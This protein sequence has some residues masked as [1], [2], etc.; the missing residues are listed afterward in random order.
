VAADETKPTIWNIFKKEFNKVFQELL[1]FES[2]LLFDNTPQAINRLKK[3]LDPTKEYLKIEIELTEGG[4]GGKMM[5]IYNAEVAT[6][7]EYFMLMGFSEKLDS[8]ESSTI[9]AN[10][11][12]TQNLLDNVRSGIT[13][14]D[15][16]IY[17][18]TIK[19]VSM[20]IDTNSLD[21]NEYKSF[22]S[23]NWEQ[24]AMEHIVSDDLF[25]MLSFFAESVLDPKT[26]D[27][28]INKPEDISLPGEQKQEVYI[29]EI[30]DCD[31]RKT[32]FKEELDNLKLILNVE[33]K[34]TVRIGTKLMLLKDIVNIDIGTTIEL[35]QLAS[36][37][38][39]LLINGV[40]IAEG[41]VV[42]V[43][44][45]FGIQIVKI[46]SK[47]ERLSKLKFKS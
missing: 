8:I 11:E 32:I 27:D 44:G 24:S 39:D 45:K 28:D 13:A 4:K 41:E 30:E 18:F 19:K 25:L 42:V 37:P 36:E 29:V 34:L 40:K 47:I 12:F 35:E 20:V 7:I 43:E 9:D 22:L 21:V 16:G 6:S 46:S 17:D 31:K 15:L 23:F 5:L 1:H 10:Q 38:L 33:L 14:Q 2:E 3:T 26:E